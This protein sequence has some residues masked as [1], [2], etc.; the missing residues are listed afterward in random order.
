MKKI[1]CP[2]DFSPV[3]ENAVTYA[4]EI[5]KT[6]GASL[7][8][9]HA[10]LLSELT[11]EEV[12]V[13]TGMSNAHLEDMLNK[14]CLEVSNTYK[15]SCNPEPVTSARWLAKNIANTAKDFD[16]VVMGTNGEDDFF[17]RICGSMTYRVIKRTGIPVIVVPE[18][19][20]YS[21][22]NHIAYAFDYWRIVTVPM[23][24]VVELSQ[25]LKCG[26]T[27][28]QVMEAYSPDAERELRATEEVLKDKYGDIVNLSF[29]TLYD[30][31]VVD[32]LRKFMLKGDYNALALCFRD[33]IGAHLHTRVIREMTSDMWYP[34]IAFH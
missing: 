28:V 4:A 10:N 20:A 31:N 2:T 5:A 6:I 12:L 34:L 32:A 17:Q 19:C 24:K 33:G 7:H 16:L 11:P 26:V 14:E 18:Q 13:G 21:K 30:A 25:A 9:I 29:K 1:L 23:E 22:I 8:L 27:L 15:I 3:G